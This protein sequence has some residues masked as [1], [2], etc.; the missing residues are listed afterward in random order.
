MTS[1]QEE[2]TSCVR[3]MAAHVGP[4][5]PACGRGGLSAFPFVPLS[6]EAAPFNPSAA[7]GSQFHAVSDAEKQFCR[8]A[9]KL[10]TL[11]TNSDHLR[12]EL[13]LLFDQLLSENYNKTFD[14][15]FNVR[16]EVTT[17]HKV[18]YESVDLN[19]LMED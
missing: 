7:G 12:D 19:G 4:A 13:N 6:P 3:N 15:D 8:C 16:A 1:A 10:R 17:S 14:V 9:A 11:G 5:A 18:L 2:N